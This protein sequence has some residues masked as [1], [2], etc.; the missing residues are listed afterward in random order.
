M[1]AIDTDA[2]IIYATLFHVARAPLF[3]S[4]GFRQAAAIL[5]HYA[6]CRR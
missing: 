4:F 2:A 6:A 1:L 3:A 5:R